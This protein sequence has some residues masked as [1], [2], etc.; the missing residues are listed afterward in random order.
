MVCWA[1]LFETMDLGT[2]SG[3]INLTETSVQIQSMETFFPKKWWTDLIG[4]MIGMVQHTSASC[5]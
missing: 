3:K 1:H 5:L 2:G 4:I